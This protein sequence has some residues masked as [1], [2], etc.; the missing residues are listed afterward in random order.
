MDKGNKTNF[1]KLMDLL[2]ITIIKKRFLLS[3]K[4]YTIYVLYTPYKHRI[5]KVNSNYNKFPYLK[6]DNIENVKKWC[7]DN[8]YE[9]RKRK[10]KSNIWDL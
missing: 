8:E 4:K 1:D 3:D 6:G 5:Y 9:Y 2:V 10:G 7:D